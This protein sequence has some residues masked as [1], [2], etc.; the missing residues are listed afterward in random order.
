MERPNRQIDQYIFAPYAKPFLHIKTHFNYT[1]EHGDLYQV[2]LG[3][4]PFVPRAGESLMFLSQGETG[5]WNQQVRVR[6]EKVSYE[7]FGHL[8]PA[9]RTWENNT[10]GT[11]CQVVLDVVPLD[12]E[13]RAYMQTVKDSDFHYQG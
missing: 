5:I 8:L 12:E 2:A 1:D 10:D 4:L 6:V 13:A 7:L 11:G 9:S 3:F